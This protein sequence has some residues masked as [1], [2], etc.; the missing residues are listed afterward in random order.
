MS[1]S[2]HDWCRVSHTTAPFRIRLYNWKSKTEYLPES[3]QPMLTPYLVQTVDILKNSPPRLIQV[4][5]QNH[6]TL[7]VWSGS[8][9]AQSGLTAIH[10]I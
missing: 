9:S 2:C 10:K 3:G 4:A 7:R 8:P 6:L 5:G 1:V